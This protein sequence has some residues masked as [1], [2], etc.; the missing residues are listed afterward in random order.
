[1]GDVMK[2]REK[3]NCQWLRI[4][5]RGGLTV[6]GITIYPFIFYRKP[7][8]QVSDRLRRHEMVHIAQVRRD[9][10]LRFYFNYLRESTRVPYSHISYEKEA[11]RKQG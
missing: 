10:W 6:A 4:L 1:V 9:G 5:D 8:N 7:K 11:Y 3:Y 2:I